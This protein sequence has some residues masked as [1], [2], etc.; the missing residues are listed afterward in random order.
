MAPR[1]VKRPSDAKL[2]TLE[3]PEGLLRKAQKRAIDEGTSFKGLVEK[4]LK[5]YLRG[6]EKRGGKQH[7][8]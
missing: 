4:L 6:V 5:E 1:R 2:T 7:G 8:R 3:L